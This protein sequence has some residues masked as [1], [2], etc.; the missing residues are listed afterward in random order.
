MFSS[1]VTLLYI[2]DN[3]SFAEA[4][5]ENFSFKFC[6]SRSGRKSVDLKGVTFRLVFYYTTSSIK[7]KPKL[8]QLGPIE[9]MHIH[10][11]V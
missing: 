4:V 3:L 10:H 5:C 9:I 2:L 7:P 1:T 8:V 11:Q 6:P